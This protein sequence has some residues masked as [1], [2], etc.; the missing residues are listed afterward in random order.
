MR[1]G[2]LDHHCDRDEAAEQDLVAEADAHLGARDVAVYDSDDEAVQDVHDHECARDG[3]CPD[4]RLG[5]L[6]DDIGHATLP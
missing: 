2:K 3:N 5:Q 6:D 1:A 4:L